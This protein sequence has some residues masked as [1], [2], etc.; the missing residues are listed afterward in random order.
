MADTRF[1]MPADKL[2]PIER[3]DHGELR[4]EW[5]NAS[6]KPVTLELPVCAAVFPAQGIGHHSGLPELRRMNKP[7]DKDTKPEAY[8]PAVWRRVEIQPGAVAKIP[9]IHRTAIR[10]TICGH[11][12]CT[13]RQL[14][15]G[16]PAAHRDAQMEFGG[17]GGGLL[18]LVG[19]ET[20]PKLH[21]SLARPQEP[22][23]APVP[24]AS[25]LNPPRPMSAEELALERARE[26]RQAGGGR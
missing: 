25:V 15:C 1:W 12:D 14:A 23:A 16:N 7:Y 2:H 13:Q 26:R 21:P 22:T 11:P 8:E 9:R 4:D 3:E 24:M 10:R 6:G 5:Q 19:E 17:L 18:V 20:P